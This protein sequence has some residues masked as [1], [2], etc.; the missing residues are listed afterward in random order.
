MPTIGRTDAMENNEPCDV[1]LTVVE[2]VHPKSR[3]IVYKWF[4]LELVM[5]TADETV[6]LQSVASAE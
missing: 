5:A 1:Y 2:S 6:S 3:Q 4:D